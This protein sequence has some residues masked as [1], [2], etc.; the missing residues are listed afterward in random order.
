[1]ATLRYGCDMT[2]DLNSVVIH[3]SSELLLFLVD[4]MVF[5]CQRVCRTVNVL[6]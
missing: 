6:S 3:M 5:W 2:F 4:F 1:M